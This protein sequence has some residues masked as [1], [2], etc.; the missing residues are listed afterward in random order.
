MEMGSVSIRKYQYQ[1]FVTLI[2]VKQGHLRSPG[3]KVKQKI[4]LWA[5]QYIFAMHY[6]FDQIFAK[7]KNVKRP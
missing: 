1:C 5:L 4:E 7:K 3:Q 2:Q 6:I